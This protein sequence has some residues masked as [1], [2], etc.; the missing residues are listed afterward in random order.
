LPNLLKEVTYLTMKSLKKYDIVLPSTYS[1][2][3]E[4]IAIELEVDF[5]NVE[6]L[7][8]EINQ[9]NEQV[10]IVVKKT[11]DN[12]DML[13]QSTTNAQKAIEIN[14]QESLK[15]IT[16]ELIKMKKQINFLQKELFSD[17]LTGAY[18]RRWFSDYYLQDE[19]FQNDGFIA[20]IDLDK[21]K[22]INDKYG[23]IIGDQVLKYLVKFLEKELVYSGIDIVRYA[24][25]EFLL[26]F[27]KNKS[28]ILNAE[29]IVTDIQ[30]KISHQKLKSSKIKELQFSFSF[31]FSHFS[32]GDY[33]EDILNQVDDLM[34]Q[35][36]Q[37]NA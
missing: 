3:F 1:K 27:N 21:F 26:L 23:H 33:A 5:D 9:D 37:R 7:L 13:H 32:K 35:N 25:D 17:P 31:G 28:T 8:K 30:E 29:K 36:K 24:G 11:N 6:V 4:K 2:T 10:D 15:E 22:R 16:S 18:N 20:F 14:D 19:R 12:L 34:Y